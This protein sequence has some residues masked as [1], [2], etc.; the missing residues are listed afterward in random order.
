[1]SVLASRAERVKMSRLLDA[2]EE[3]LAF[4]DAIDPDDVARVRERIADLLHEQGAGAFDNLLSASRLLPDA[5][6]AKIAQTVFS[7]VISALVSGKLE[8]KRARGLIGHIDVDYLADMAPHLDPRS[9]ADVVQALPDDVMVATAR[10]INRRGD[11]VSAGRL[12]GVA[13]DRVIPKFLDAIPDERDLLEIAFFL[14]DTS[15]LDAIVRHVSSDRVERLLATAEREGLWAE[16]MVLTGHLSEEET[17]RIAAVAADAPEHTV[18]NL[19][20]STHDQDLWEP[21]LPLVGHMSDED[22]RKVAGA[23]MLQR[24]EVLAAVLHGAGR[25]G[26]WQTVV[27]VVAAMDHDGRAAVAESLPV[28]TGQQRERLAQASADLGL[29]EDL[30]PVA[31]R[32]R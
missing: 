29:T 31:A 20:A 26:A 1:M 8:P 19:L 25:S 15:R 5:V 11:H 18:H 7:P 12:V 2:S 32:L 3:E 4:L 22:L 10:E 27:R 9:I 14:E 23:G 6:T 17:A 13:P 21:L 30:G 16:A 28:L 24:T